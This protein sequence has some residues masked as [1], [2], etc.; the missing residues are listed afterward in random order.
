MKQTKW[1]REQHQE[2]VHRLTVGERAGTDLTVTTATFTTSKKNLRDFYIFLYYYLF[3]VAGW[4]NRRGKKGSKPLLSRHIVIMVVKR[5]SGN[6]WYRQP[7]SMKKTVC[8]RS[9]G[10]NSPVFSPRNR[11]IGPAFGLQVPRSEVRTPS[12]THKSI[13]NPSQTSCAD[14]LS[15][16]P[17]PCV[18]IRTLK[19][20][21]VRTFT[22]PVVHVRVRWITET[23]KDPART[24]LTGG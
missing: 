14:S 5:S 2:Q 23:R 16:C 13:K 10:N 11:S 12:G 20:D 6:L 22:D 4:L 3:V 19:G 9:R 24:L 21:P 18:Y 17:T 7:I 8:P 1:I 15:V